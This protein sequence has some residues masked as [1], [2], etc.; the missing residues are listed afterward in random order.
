MH[1]IGTPGLWLAFLIFVIFVL[2][3]D[4]FILGKKKSHIVTTREALS[5]TIVWF[6]CAMLFM[7]MLWFYLHQAGDPVLANQKTLEFFTGY[8]IEETLS[9]DNMFVFLMIFNYFSVPPE[10]QRRVLLYG[11]L[12]AIVMR[13]VMILFG[14]WLI[15]Q[16]HWVLYLFGLFLVITGVKMLLFADDKKDL[17]DNIVLNWLRRHLRVTHQFHNEHF[18]IRQHL[19]WYATPLFLVLVMI[20]LSDLI[21]ALDSIPAIFAITSDPFIIFTS[22]IFAILGLR[23]LYFLLAGMAA[24]FHLLKYGIA[25]ILVFIGG[26]MVLE[27]W[28]HMPIWVTLIVVVTI[29]TTT[30]LLSLLPRK[31]KTWKH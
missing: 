10:Y 23:A 13:L 25:I 11:V 12:G 29:L 9:V 19:M 30:V 21:F 24:R 22:N 14:V 7:A 26:K 31:E 27:K 15:S 6:T 16:L 3:I 2:T 18:F 8:L 20:E 17:S 28:L 4:I 1:S 5:W